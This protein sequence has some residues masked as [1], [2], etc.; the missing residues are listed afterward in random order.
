MTIQQL[1]EKLD[2]LPLGIDI[3]L[4]HIYWSIEKAL[5]LNMVIKLEVVCG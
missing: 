4:S 2:I 5:N 1:V 3:L